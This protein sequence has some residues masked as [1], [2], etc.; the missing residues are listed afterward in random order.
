MFRIRFHGRGGQGMK[1]ASR[2]LGNAFFLEGYDVQDAPRYGAER[3]GAPIFAYV[4][5]DRKPVYERGVINRPDI[6]LVADDTLMKISAAGVMQGVLEDTVLLIYSDVSS[7]EWKNSL[8]SKCRIVAFSFSDSD[9][10]V[11]AHSVGEYAVGAALFGAA[12]RLSGVIARENLEKAVR[13]EISSHGEKAAEESVRLSLRAFDEL[14]AHSGAAREGEEIRVDSS[15]VPDWIDLPFDRAE[16]SGPAIHSPATSEL[17]KTGLWR[18]ERPVLNPELCQHCT[19]VCG[20]FCPD[21]AISRGETG[22]PVID[23]EH[24]KGCMI[25]F[26][27]CP[28]HAISAHSEREHR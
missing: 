27:S 12:A 6:V 15:A 14:S 21:G 20:S 1:T 4:R 10:E 17:V 26:A 28:L 25:C 18:T 13:D 19:W 5:A 2:F 7:D 23:Y 3:R 16:I 8:N 11:G 24:C 9:S 22:E